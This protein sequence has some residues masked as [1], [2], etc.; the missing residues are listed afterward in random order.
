MVYRM[1]VISKTGM[2]EAA[3]VTMFDKEQQALN[4]AREWANGREVELW[5]ADR[6]VARIAAHQKNHQKK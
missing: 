3:S 5:D 2:I 4:H 6:L 1:Y